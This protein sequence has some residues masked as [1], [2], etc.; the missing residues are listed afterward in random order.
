MRRFATIF[1]LV[2]TLGLLAGCRFP[3]GNGSATANESSAFSPQRGQ[4]SHRSECLPSPTGKGGPMC[5]VP[6]GTFMMG[7]DE[8]RYSA[9]DDDEKPY[10]EVFLSRYLID[11]HEVTV[12]EYRICVEAG[13]CEPPIWHHLWGQKYCNFNQANR[14]TH[15]QN[16]VRWFHAQ[17]YCRWAGKRLPTEAEWEKAARG[18]DGALYAWGDAP[19]VSC[20]LAVIDDGRDGC[21]TNSTWPV[22]AKPLGKGPYGTCDMAGNLY[23]WNVDWYDP[24][25]FANSPKRDPKGPATGETRVLKGGSWNQKEWKARASNR[26]GY[27]PND[28]PYCR[29]FRC[30]FAPGP[31]RYAGK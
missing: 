16:C 19:E 12:A 22:C 26:V 2:F 3:I 31:E 10:H 28:N 27:P 5:E 20:D 9:C 7:C 1:V 29:G 13:A 23:E 24:R 25:Y 17:D 11:E 14:D 21:G 6:E 8:R 4:T 18:T 30:A 15:P